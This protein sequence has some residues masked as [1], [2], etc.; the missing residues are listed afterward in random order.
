MQTP[1]TTR[2]A[3]RA[4]SSSSVAPGAL[5]AATA[6]L[7]LAACTYDG[8]TAGAEVDASA[9]GY[10]PAA[11]PSMRAGQGGRGGRPAAEG[12]L[13][14][15]AAGGEGEVMREE[16]AGFGYVDRAGVEWRAL[17]RQ[18]DDFGAYGQTSFEELLAAIRPLEGES[19]EDYYQRQL[20]TRPFVPT[21]VDA[22]STFGLETDTASYALARAQLEAGALPQPW[23]VRVEEFVQRS[24][25]TSPRPG[26]ATSR[27]RPTSFPVRSARTTRGSVA[28]VCARATWPSSSAARSR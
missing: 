6:V 19:P 3:S 12:L 11:S 20:M 24:T 22:V 15:R 10:A 21:S 9:A 23:S 27:S 13:S 26:A 14:L 16:L 1:S 8:A 17:D 5:L 28:S 18:S 7:G 25:A 4:R 2:R